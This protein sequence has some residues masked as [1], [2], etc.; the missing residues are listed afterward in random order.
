MSTILRQRDVPKTIRSLSTL[1]RVDY[2]D[3]F[4]AT[5]D[6]TSAS[7]E[8][9]ARAAMEDTA[10]RGG[11][12]VWRGPCGLRL[13]S[14]RS[15]D[16]IAGWRIAGRGEDWIRTEASSWFMTAQLVVHIE[17]QLLSVATLVRYDRRAAALLWPTLSIVHRAAMPRLLA[18]TVRRLAKRT[19]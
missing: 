17:G 12:L 4:T 11:Q 16:H 10:G 3:M 15:P 5:T 6:G 19:G 9:W 14:G 2:A 18:G 1:S 8:R 7:P 13:E